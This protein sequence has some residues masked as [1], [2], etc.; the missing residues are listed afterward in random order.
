MSVFVIVNEFEPKG[1]NPSVEIVGQ[2]GP[3]YWTTQNG[4][5]EELRN[6]A[7]ALDVYIG[8]DDTDFSAP[9]PNDTHLE[10]DEYSIIELEE[11]EE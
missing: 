11:A 6:M 7:A 5:W 3:K 10:Y 1:G 8:A 4:A 9:L 2:D